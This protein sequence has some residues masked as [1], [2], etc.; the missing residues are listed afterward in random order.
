MI[1][2]KESIRL[3][4]EKQITLTWIFGLLFLG[5]AWSLHSLILSQHPTRDRA[6]SSAR[7]LELSDLPREEMDENSARTPWLSW[8]PPSTLSAAPVE[9]RAN[10]LLDIFSIANQTKLNGYA[11]YIG[12]KTAPG[13]NRIDRFIYCQN[14]DESAL[15]VMPELVRTEVAGP[16]RFPCFGFSIPELKEGMS[17]IEFIGIE[18]LKL[19]LSPGFDPA[20]GGTLTIS[21]LSKPISFRELKLSI[22]RQANGSFKVLSPRGVPFTQLD[23]DFRPSGLITKGFP[24]G[25]AGL[26]LF[27]TSSVSAPRKSLGK[28]NVDRDLPRRE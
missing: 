27:Q 21:F 10:V 4:P 9:H 23:L 19:K 3:R 18:A 6:P 22:T 7:I 20:K 12:Y 17:L 8:A 24:T 11:S 14:F 5:A 2:K 1:R 16:Q 25:L 26:E 15:R 28:I 13:T